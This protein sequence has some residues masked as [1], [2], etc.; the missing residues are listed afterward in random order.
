MEVKKIIPEEK[1]TEDVLSS[2]TYNLKSG[3]L[4]YAALENTNPAPSADGTQPVTAYNALMG[5]TEATQQQNTGG[6]PFYSMEDEINARYDALLEAEKLNIQKNVELGKTKYEADLAKALPE[7]QKK[8]EQQDYLTKQNE[9]KIKEY[10]FYTGDRGGM[11][12]QDMLQNINSGQEIIGAIN[13]QEQLLKD[14][15]QRAITELFMRGEMDSAIAEAKYAAQRQEALANEKIRLQESNASWTKWLSSE[16]GYLP[17]GQKSL[18]R[19]QFEYRKEQDSRSNAYSGG[20]GSYSGGGYY[21]EP[22]QETALNQYRPQA[23]SNEFHAQYNDDGTWQPYYTSDGLKTTPEDYRIPDG[24]VDKVSWIIDSAAQYSDGADI[25]S[26]ITDTMRANVAMSYIGA[27]YNN[28]TT[29]QQD[30]LLNHFN[31]S[32][33]D[34]LDYFAP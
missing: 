26:G 28:L 6:G 1:L 12:R 8:K 30:M 16:T 29:G 2:N 23:Y 13:L 27:N 17:D 4:A 24:T 33:R 7:Y 25:M 18:S 20:G 34:L 5:D 21:Q 14:D 19:E 15:T 32:R 10:A 31:L 22:V 11:S 3:S 9:Q